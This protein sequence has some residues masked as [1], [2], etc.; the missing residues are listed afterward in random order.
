ML[1]GAR[2]RDLEGRRVRAV[3][4]RLLRH[5]A[6]ILHGAGGGR[7][8]LSVLLEELDGLVID[9]R[10][11]IV[12]DDADRVMLLAIRSPAL[13]AARMS[14]GI[15]ASMITS[16]G[17]C[18]LVMPR[19]LSTMYI[20]GRSAMQASI[21]A[22]IS[23]SPLTLLQ[24]SPRPALGFTPSAVDLF[25]ML[26][27]HRRQECFDRMAKDDR[28]G[29]LHHRGLH[30]QEN[31]MPSALVFSISSRKERLKRLGAHVGG[32]DH[33]PLRI[34]EPVLQTRLLARRSSTIF[35]VA[36]LSSVAE[37]LV[38]KKSPPDMEA[39][40][41]LLSGDHSP[42]RCGLACAYFFTALAARAV[43]IA[44][45]QHGVH[46]RALDRVVARLRA[47]FSASVCGF[48]G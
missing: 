36:A 16:E 15:E 20:G 18:R 33:R 39:T 48:S 45:A 34:A 44:L 1:H 43:R 31:S 46:R 37:H 5:Q 24:Q 25:A 30:M 11:G 23:G 3:F 17:T 42:M 8:E 2:R 10:I 9:R 22:M 7:V 4:L 27:E 21:A 6:D 32:V 35:A 28:V 13:A 12:G 29:D 40:R 14:A 41:V 19:S 47:S 38:G 26:L